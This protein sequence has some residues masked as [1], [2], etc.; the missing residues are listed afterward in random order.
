MFQ[1]RDFHY[2]LE[3]DRLRFR[4]FHDNSQGGLVIGQ[5]LTSITLLEFLSL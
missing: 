1:R 5:F 4:S 2:E 3:Q